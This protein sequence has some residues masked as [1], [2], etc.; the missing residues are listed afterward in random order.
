MY[1]VIIALLIAAGLALV[2]TGVNKK[3]RVL[4]ALGVAVWVFTALVFGLLS[5]WGEM[6]WFRE[7]GFQWRFWTVILSRAGLGLAGALAGCLV[8]FLLTLPIPRSKKIARIW[9]EIAGACLGAL[10]GFNSWEVVLM[11]LNRASSGMVEPILGRDV[12]F[13]LFNLPFYDLV[14][15][16][17]FLLAGLSLLASLAAAFLRL[18]GEDVQV[19]VP[20]LGRAYRP[21][22]VSLA[23]LIL[24]FAWGQYLN[25]FHLLN[26]RLGVVRR[27]GGGAGSG[28]HTSTDRTGRPGVRQLLSESAG[29]LER[30]QDALD[31]L[32]E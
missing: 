18:S 31:R 9:P 10:I 25:R 22:Y 23:A 2:L 7:L 16:A 3:M 14:Y 20:D 21:V 8:V 19:D 28:R 29:E 5:F 17:L 15:R 26:S 12:A 1:L 32:G 11:F 24:V 13:Y 27:D 6:L 4:A 30:L